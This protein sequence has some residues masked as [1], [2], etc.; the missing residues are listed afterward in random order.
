[1]RPNHFSVSLE[2]NVTLSKKCSPTLICAIG[3]CSCSKR[4]PASCA[5]K[6]AMGKVITEAAPAA[7]CLLVDF[8]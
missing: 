1:M 3:S 4:G 2:I 8:T 5:S 7:D 6:S